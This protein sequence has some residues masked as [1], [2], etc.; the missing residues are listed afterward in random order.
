MLSAWLNDTDRRNANTMAVYTTRL[1][2]TRAHPEGD[3]LRYLQHY[4]LDMGSTL[5]ANGGGAHTPLH[6]NGYYTDLGRGLGHTLTLGAV[7][8]PWER[9][10]WHAVQY[11]EVGYYEADIFDPAR[12]RMTYP[13]PAFNKLTLRDAFW[14]AKRV[15]SFTDADIAAIVHGAG[16][17]TNPEAEAYL[18]ETMIRRRD[19]IA[20]YWFGRVNPLDR[21]AVS[22]AGRLAWEDLAVAYGLEPA[23]ARYAVTVRHRGR[24]IARETVAAPALALP[25]LPDPA[26]TDGHDRVLEVE[27]RTLRAAAAPSKA[28]TVYVHFPAGAAPR[29]AG[30]VREE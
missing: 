23:T 4:L 3:T 13:N 14:G 28:T 8:D 17:L 16:R 12:W 20:R 29:L 15:V 1:A 22:E 18:I 11:P 30:I 27:L 2:P 6:G 25:P 26:A 9:E 5:G 10:A 21:F 19:K 7:V 24:E